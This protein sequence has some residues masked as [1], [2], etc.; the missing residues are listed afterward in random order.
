MYPVCLCVFLDRFVQLLPSPTK[1]H[2]CTHVQHIHTLVASVL[3]CGEVGAQCKDYQC[4]NSW[5]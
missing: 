2:L 1:T 3:C 4:S 5:E